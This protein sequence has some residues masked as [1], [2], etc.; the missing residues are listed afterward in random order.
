[1]FV[2]MHMATDTTDPRRACDQSPG[3]EVAS[4]LLLVL[5]TEL[6]SSATAVCVPNSVPSLVPISHMSYI[7]TLKA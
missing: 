4:C 1:M 7:S 3:A 2:P 5:G 6:W